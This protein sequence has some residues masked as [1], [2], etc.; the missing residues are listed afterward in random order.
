[1]GYRGRVAIMEVLIT[2]VELERLISAADSTDAIAD[3]ARNGGMRT[4]WESGVEQVRSGVTDIGELLRVVEPPME[5]GGSLPPKR[6][7]TEDVFSPADAGKVTSSTSASPRMATPRGGPGFLPAEVLELVDDEG[8]GGRGGRQT[9]LLVEDEEALRGVLKDLLEREGY[10]II[11]ASDG[12]QALDEIDRNAPDA[13]VLDL[14][15]PRLDGYGVLNH[16][17]ARPTTAALPVLVLTA[18]A[19]EDNEVRVF[20]IGANDFITKPFRPRALS[21]RLK[22]LLNRP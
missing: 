19:D 10:A 14:S 1:M 20:E 4:L 15:L 18:K 3:A 6:A 17:R 8:P 22:A 7:S 16:L 21:A 13:V 11:E 9:V 5:L 12:I 2:T